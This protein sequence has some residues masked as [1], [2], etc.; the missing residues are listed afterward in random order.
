M[1]PEFA[2]G[3]PIDWPTSLPGNIN[4]IFPCGSPKGTF[5]L[6]PVPQLALV[7]GTNLPGGPNNMAESFLLWH[8]HQ[9]LA[10]HRGGGIRIMTA[11]AAGSGA[12]NVRIPRRRP[13]G[14]HDA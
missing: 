4:A 14:E 10:A 5:G 3:V 2:C 6:L 7:P 1:L 13:A 12:V 11:P 9:H 8:R